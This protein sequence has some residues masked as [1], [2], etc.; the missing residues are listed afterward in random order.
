MMNIVVPDRCESFFYAISN[1]KTQLLEYNV[2]D[3]ITLKFPNHSRVRKCFKGQTITF[4]VLAIRKANWGYNMHW[5]GLLPKGS[6]DKDEILF[7]APYWRFEALMIDLFP[8][9]RRPYAGWKQKSPSII[10]G[11]P[12]I[13]PKWH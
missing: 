12:I 8:I 10:N 3:E 6:N 7:V 2:G 4:D 1:K 13:E 9:N 11:K 5:L